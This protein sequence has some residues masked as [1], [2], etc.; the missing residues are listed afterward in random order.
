MS[1]FLSIFI[2]DLTIHIFHILLLFNVAAVTA[3]RRKEILV[4]LE[5]S[6]KKCNAEWKSG[7]WWT[8]LNLSFND[9]FRDMINIII[10]PVLKI[11]TVYSLLCMIYYCSWTLFITAFI[12]DSTLAIPWL[13]STLDGVNIVDTLCSSNY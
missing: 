4:R 12:A 3:G 8:L 7:G 13:K 1:I 2:N 11:S 5:N 10:N 6:I 9:R